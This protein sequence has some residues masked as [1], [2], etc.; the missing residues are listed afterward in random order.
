M[1]HTG[2]MDATLCTQDTYDAYSPSVKTQ[3]QTHSLLWKNVL[4]L[5][6]L[7]EQDATDIPC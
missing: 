1:I 2:Y 5:S 3:S 7:I 4:K 6:L